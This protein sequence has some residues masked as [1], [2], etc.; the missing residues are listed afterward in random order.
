MSIVDDFDS[1]WFNDHENLRKLAEW[2]RTNRGWNFFKDNILDVLET[3]WS[4]EKEWR[5]ANGDV[6]F[7]ELHANDANNQYTVDAAKCDW[8]G[9]PVGYVTFT[10][11]EADDQSI[12]WLPV[13]EDTVT[14]EIACDDCAGTAENFA[15]TTKVDTELFPGIR[16][17]HLAIVRGSQS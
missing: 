15:E 2:L 4:W 14:G 8:C 12:E 7:V 10:L 17:T 5:L 16:A 6:T 13:F 11:N 3:P 1:K 9:N